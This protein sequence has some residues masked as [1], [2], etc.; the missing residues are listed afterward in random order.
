MRQTTGAIVCPSCGKLV[1]VREPRC[2]F[3]GAWRPGMF[4]YATPIARWLGGGLDLTAGIVGACAVLY[5]FSL[6]LDLP[7]VLHGGLMNLLGPGDRAL[8]QLGM[9][10]GAAWRMRWWWTLLTATFLHGGILHILFNMFAVRYYMPSVLHL[11]GAARSFTLY[12]L[13]GATGF[14][15]SNVVSGAPTIGASCSIFGLLAALV[16]YGRRTGQH[17]VSGQLLQLA[18]IMFLFG[19]FMPSVNNWGHAGGFIGGWIVA[20]L[21][22][23]AVGH[24]DGP[25]DVVLASALAIATVGGVVASFVNVTAI[26]VRH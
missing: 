16:V 8:Y 5:V 24:R 12:M 19:F 15:L 14:L 7:A 21:M 17:A 23:P 6:V 9:T 13:S 11:Y 4:G 25:L 22:V 20:E 2:P 1:D 18:G 26:L 10:G 3:C